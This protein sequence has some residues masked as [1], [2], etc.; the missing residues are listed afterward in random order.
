MRTGIFGDNMK[1]ISM[2]LAVAAAVTALS[3]CVV[4][5]PRHTYYTPA[6]VTVAP[7]APRVEVITAPP[8]AGHIWIGGAWF[9]EGGHHVWHE[10]HWEAPRPGYVW[11]PHRWEQYNGGWRFHEGHWDRH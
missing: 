6:V 10:G 2:V 9:W 3:G 8:V 4:E 11:V 7:P 1:R 5:A